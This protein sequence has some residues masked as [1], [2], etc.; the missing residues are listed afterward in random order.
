MSGHRQLTGEIVLDYLGR[1]RTTSKCALARK[2][3]N[4]NKNVF[5]TVSAV[6]SAIN[7]YCG[8]IGETHRKKTTKRFVVH[9]PLLPEPI[10]D[11]FDPMPINASTT[12][13]LSDI[14]LPF[15][16][17]IA[18]ETAVAHGRKIKS[19]CVVLNGDILDCHSLSRF[20]KDPRVRTLKKEVDICNSFIEWIRHKFPK[21]RILWR[22]G[23]HEHRYISYMA[24]KAVELLDM[25]E[26]Q[27]DK[28]LGVE[29]HGV[30]WVDDGKWLQFG[31]LAVIHGHELAGGAGGVNPARAAFLR[32]F[33]CT[34]IGHYHKTSQHAE[35][36]AFDGRTTTTWSQGCLCNLNPRYLR[37][38]RWN[39][40]CC[41]IRMSTKDGFHLENLRIIDGK[42]Y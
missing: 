23:N 42:V 33:A 12:L 11:S 24:S 21:S 19:D 32:T 30:E 27:F 40:G 34:L 39:C 22:K 20:E 13:C 10:P 35:G 25:D 8:T 38:N 14:H 29:R 6:R 31:H 4:E 18:L 1:F 3:Y 9:Q 5:R 36:H 28:V 17:N 7:Y 16:N 15:H 41:V 2:I 26:F 37:I